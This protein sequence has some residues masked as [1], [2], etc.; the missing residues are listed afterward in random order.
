M[1]ATGVVAQHSEQALQP[2]S[3]YAALSLWRV[4]PDSRIK[5]DMITAR[6]VR[7]YLTRTPFIPFRICLSDQS[8]HDVA[9]PEFAWVIGPRIFVGEPGKDPLGSDTNVRELSDLHIARLDPLKKV[10]KKVRE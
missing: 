9:H 3:L 7:A 5:S 2:F 4:H 10:G 6:H 8:H 1:L